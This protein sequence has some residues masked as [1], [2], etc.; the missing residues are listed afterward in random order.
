MASSHWSTNPKLS[1]A[2][3]F[4]IAAVVKE[5][6]DPKQCQCWALIAEQGQKGIQGWQ[7]W[8]LEGCPR[9]LLGVVPWAPCSR[10]SA[11]PVNPTLLSLPISQPGFPSQKAG[12]HSWINPLLSAPQVDA[13]EVPGAAA[14]APAIISPDRSSCCILSPLPVCFPRKKNKVNTC[15]DK[16]N[17]HTFITDPHFPLVSSS[18]TSQWDSAHSWIEKPFSLLRGARKAEGM[19]Q[20][21]QHACPSCDDGGTAMPRAAQLLPSAPS[22]NAPGYPRGVY[23]Y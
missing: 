3:P 17:K 7:G 22:R 2:C 8:A 21:F 13:K 16:L 1:S 5:E 15:R 14:S 20:P 10:G 4:T 23:G 18:F 11:P 19:A 9:E 6:Q 12:G